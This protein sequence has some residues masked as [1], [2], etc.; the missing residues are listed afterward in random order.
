LATRNELEQEALRHTQRGNYSKAA[1]IYHAILRQQPRD[2]RVR[3]KLGEI[4]LKMGQKKEGAKYLRE[5]AGLA[6]REGQHRVAIA[7]Y[8]QLSQ[9]LGDDL[10]I[11]GALADC[12]RENN[13][14]HEATG[15]YEKALNLAKNTRA[16]QPAV[17]YA[18]ALSKM[19][20]SDMAL[21]F[22]LAEL[23]ESAG[24]I[25]GALSDY[26]RMAA[27]FTRR[28]EM[29]E[30]ARVAEAALR[31]G[32]GE[33]NPEFLAL[34][35]RARVEAG[36]FDRALENAKPVIDILEQQPPAVIEALGIALQRRG[37]E[38]KARRLLL[39]VA[40]Q[41]RDVGDSEGQ[42]R[43]LG[44]ALE[45]GSDDPKLREAF[46]QAKAR[47]EKLKRRLSDESVL[48]PA[49]DEELIIC[50]KAEVQ[51]RYGFPDRAVATL[52]GGAK[53]LPKSFSVGA[54]RVE[55]LLDLG[56]KDDALRLLE[57]MVRAA[58][59]SARTALAS[60]LLIL[61]GPDLL[62]EPDRSPEAGDDTS[63]AG[64]DVQL[65]LSDDEDLLEDDADLL[66][67]DADLL[68]DEEEL[69]EDEELLTDEELETGSGDAGTWSASD[70][71]DALL[72]DDDLDGDGPLARAEALVAEGDLDA[73][74]AA[75]Q[76]AFREDPLNDEIL[77]R[78]AEVRRQQR[79]ARD[80]PAPTELS[81]SDEGDIDEPGPS[82]D[83]ELGDLGFGATAQGGGRGSEGAPLIAGIGQPGSSATG[84][85]PG[86]WKDLLGGGKKP[87]APETESR[88][89]PEFVEVDSV[90]PET[91]WA[92][93]A[94]ERYQ[95]ALDQA[96]GFTGLMGRWLEARALAGLGQDDKALSVLRDALEEADEGHA[97]YPEAL[98]LLALLQMR[99]GRN[100]AALRVARELH[101]DFPDF[102]SDEISALIRGLAILR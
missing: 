65:E 66:E 59:G 102:R 54:R 79:Q 20:P 48:A 91:A 15:V 51:A 50:T 76:D 101:A 24:D 7:I 40:M 68:E 32:E 34:A 86:R 56:R 3:Q 9:L 97:V 8:R 16:W 52:E 39:D 10:E 41:Y 4:Y 25:D 77:M 5:V 18:T 87:A 75:F 61:G 38:T 45:A 78:I 81:P 1:R 80:E 55:I 53:M 23:R 6:Q 19:K 63:R 100:R 47:A 30:V 85:S 90:D 22:T 95:Q 89:E 83:D 73:A 42:A 72:D 92:L 13:Q 11:I 71:Q 57:R 84:A 29:N 69:L 96:R 98:H 17:E 99:H 64:A 58:S 88:S 31:L 14:L 28:G 93:L 49:S 33:P 2:R 82:D 12:Y 43:A 37:E 46:S 35:I 94:V 44:L 26:R 27:S 36:D 21:Q 62:G 67:D 70:G 60:R 74:I